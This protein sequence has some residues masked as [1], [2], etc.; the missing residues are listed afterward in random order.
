MSSICFLVAAKGKPHNDNAVR[1]PAAFRAAGW[2]VA[3]HDHN[4]LCLSQ[5]T[6][7][8]GSTNVDDFDLVWPVGLGEKTSF[9]DRAQLLLG[10]EPARMVTSAQALLCHHA[11]LDLIFGP[12]SAHHPETHASLDA[13]WLTGVV[14]AGGEWV[15]KPTAA[16]FG[17]GVFRVSRTD[18]QS[19]CHS[20]RAD[21]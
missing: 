11:K 5:R 10:V 1:L 4:T 12:L 6:L 14:A 2:Q 18:P 13:G 7:R 17:R 3:V 15:A 16:S 8:A 19:S 9:L 20:Q 21:G